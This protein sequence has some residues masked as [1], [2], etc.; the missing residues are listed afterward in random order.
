MTNEIG[1][2]FTPKWGLAGIQEDVMF[3]GEMSHLAT[4]ILTILSI[5]TSSWVNKLTNSV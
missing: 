2:Y 4:D 5:F 3:F 1:S